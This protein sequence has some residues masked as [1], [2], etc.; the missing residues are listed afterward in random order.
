MELVALSEAIDALNARGPGSFADAESMVTLH[1]E[2]SRLEAFVTEAAAAF[3]AGGDWANDG[4][5]TAAAWLNTRCRVP[6]SAA[7]RRIRLGRVLRDLPACA[8]AWGSGQIGPAHAAALASLHQPRT[9]EALGRD[10][11]MLLEQA[12]TLNFEEFYRALCYWKQLADPEGADRS[13]EERKAAR[14]V[15]LEPSFDGTYLG[16]MTLDPISGAIVSNEL[17]R[18]ERKLFEADCLEAKERLGRRPQMDE[19]A[20]TAGQRRADAL[21][22]MAT[23]SAVAPEHGQR[24]APLF[25]VF[26]GYETL[27]GRICEIENGIVVAPDSLIPYMEAAYF[28]RAIFTPVNRVD[29]SVRSRLFTGGTRRAVEARDRMC[30]HPY[31]SDPIDSCQVDHIWTYGTGGPTTQE[32]GRLLCGFHNRL[33]NQEEKKQEEQRS[34]AQRQR[35][36]PTHSAA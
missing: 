28:E 8:E 4:A 5:K 22:E 36:P 31:C 25:T 1:T 26:V 14:N 29:I 15:F 12:A 16:Q 13:D 9:E 27:H 6:R 35:P 24:P 30:R 34:G 18:I 11:A 7:K 20:R 17:R 33:R 21:V 10:E 19:L 32:N 23:R 2:L 3:D